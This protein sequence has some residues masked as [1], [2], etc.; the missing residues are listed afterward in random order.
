MS[1]RFSGAV[2]AEGA[3]RLAF[4]ELKLWLH[5]EQG[6]AWLVSASGVGAG[7]YVPKSSVDWLEPLRLPTLAPEGPFAAR[8]DRAI[9]ES[10]GL[11]QRPDPNQAEMF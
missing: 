7:V 4:I 5:R 6:D 9:G 11:V 1:G 2:G 3:H 8:L 10:K